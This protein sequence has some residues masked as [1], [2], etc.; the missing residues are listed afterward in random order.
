MSPQAPADGSASDG[1]YSYTVPVAALDSD[2]DCAAYSIRKQQWYDRTLVFDSEL[3][4]ESAY[5]K[6][7]FPTGAVIAGAAVLC[8]AAA[9][10]IFV[11]IKRKKAS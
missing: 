2:T 8:I 4:P 3:L 5:K 7:S 1:A 10:G 11:F 9:A 6:S